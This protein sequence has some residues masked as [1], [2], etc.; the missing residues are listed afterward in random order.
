MPFYLDAR[1]VG[2]AFVYV[3]NPTGGIFAGD[4][5]IASVI[6]EADARVHLTT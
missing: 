2:M 6:A 4:H 1:A 3:Q 5:L